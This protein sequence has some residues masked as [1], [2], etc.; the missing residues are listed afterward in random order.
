MNGHVKAVAKQGGYTIVLWDVDTKDWQI[1]SPKWIS[2]ALPLIKPKGRF[3]ILNHDIHASTVDNMDAF[4]TA[5][6]NRFPQVNFAPL[7]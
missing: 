3:I 6:R 7:T 1:R 5:I 2:H 4:I